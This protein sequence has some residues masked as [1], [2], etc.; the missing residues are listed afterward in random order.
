MYRKPAVKFSGKTEDA[1]IVIE[2]VKQK[3]IIQGRAQRAAGSPPLL[4]DNSEERK[5]YIA[6]QAPIT[7]ARLKDID[8]FIAKAR[9]YWDFESVLNVLSD[10]VTLTDT[11][12]V[13]RR[14][15]GK[16]CMIGGNG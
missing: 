3:L 14:V 1:G 15:G 9:E 16:W 5:A 10:R 4:E 13:Y 7:D 8:A 11:D 12:R 6:A 2:R